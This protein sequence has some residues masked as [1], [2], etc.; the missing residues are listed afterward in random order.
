MQPLSL[1]KCLFQVAQ[2]EVKKY[3]KNE[4]SYNP[5]LIENQL[6]GIVASGFLSKNSALIPDSGAEKLIVI[7]KLLFLN[8]IDKEKFYVHRNI[9]K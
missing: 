8:K 9:L 1:N 7:P 4:S 6:K 2:E 5:Y 3:I